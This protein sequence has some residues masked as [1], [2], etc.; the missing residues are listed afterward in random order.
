MFTSR[1]LKM[2]SVVYGSSFSISLF[3]LTDPL[4][5]FT[6]LIFQVCYSFQSTPYVH[7]ALSEHADRVRNRM[8]LLEKVVNMSSGSLVHCKIVTD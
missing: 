2:E 5:S 4:S 6:S 1:F 3:N 8:V 7:H